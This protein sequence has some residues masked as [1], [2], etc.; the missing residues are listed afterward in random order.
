MM[1]WEWRQPRRGFWVAHSADGIDWRE[2]PVNPV[3][4]V[5]D[6]TLETVTL[7][8][9]PESG[10]YFAFHRRWDSDRFRRR[11]IAVATSPDFLHWSDPRTILV[12]AARDDE[13]V[14]DDEQRSEFYGMAGFCYGGS[15]SASCRCST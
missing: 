5:D 7:A 13:W 9:H 6:E 15:S 3:L 2:Y 10:E 1:A 4:T 8:R 11:L 12:P 14:Q